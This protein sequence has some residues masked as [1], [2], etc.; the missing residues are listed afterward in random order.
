MVDQV[1]GYIPV[2]G[3]E[4][5]SGVDYVTDRW[6]ADEQKKLDDKAADETSPTTGIGMSS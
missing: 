4:I 1:I 3:D 2:G 6:L 5:Q